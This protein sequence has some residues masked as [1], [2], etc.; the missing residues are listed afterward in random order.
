MEV[1]AKYGTAAQKK[2]WLTPLLA[3]KIRSVFMMTEPLVA[4]S[5]ARNIQTS[6]TRD[7]DHYV[8]SGRKWWSRW[9]CGRSG[10]VPQCGVLTCVCLGAPRP[11]IASAAM[12]PRCR[13][14]I[15]S[16]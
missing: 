8:I 3:G 12:D 1:L 15:V 10:S 4:S 7:G 2:Q 5:D 9:V 14:A 11:P 13:I 6:I 16:A